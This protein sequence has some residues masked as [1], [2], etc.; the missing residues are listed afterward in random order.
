[1]QIRKIFFRS[2]ILSFIIVGYVFGQKPITYTVKGQV[3]SLTDQLPLPDIKVVLKDT[4]YS[5]VT[6]SLGVFRIFG[7]RRGI[8][9][10][11]AKYPDFDATILKNVAIPP[12]TKKEYIFNL[13]SN[14]KQLPY[15]DT[16][17]DGNYGVLKGQ[18]HVNID[19]FKTYF[20][21]GRLLLRAA[22]AGELT[23]SYLYPRYFEILPVSEQ[24][25]RFQ[26]NLPRGQYYHLYLIWQVEKE[27]FVF[28][29]IVDVARD[30]IN[31][32]MAKKFNLIELDQMTN[33][34]FSLET[35]K[36]RSQ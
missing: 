29:Q 14:D 10:I 35:R 17:R 30:E 6:D 34:I 25:F 23:R 3:L 13:T 31:P 32:E 20:S 33:I 1:M 21:D 36:L 5:A 11:V 4:D 26:F 7:V 22:K 27:A 15:V 24:N 12:S 19:T 18:V 8:Y 2:L 16:R 9:D 28:E